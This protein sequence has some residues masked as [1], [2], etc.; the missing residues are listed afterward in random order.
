[1]TGFIR[2][3]L[4]C[5]LFF[6]SACVEPS[7]EQ[8]FQEGMEFA[9]GGNQQ[10]AV[11][12]FKKAIE[13]DPDYLEARLE[14]GLAYLKLRQ[15][16]LADNQFT[17]IQD[18]APSNRDIALRLAK[19]YQ[20]ID[21]PDKALAVLAQ[22]DRSSPGDVEVL[23][24]MAKC[25]LQKGNYAASEEKLHQALAVKPADLQTRLGMV[26]ILYATKRADLG[27]QLLQRI[28]NESAGQTE[29]YYLQFQ[30]ALQQGDGDAAIA[31][32][33][34]I[35]EIKADDMDAA[36]LLGLIYLSAGN[37]DAARA[38]A[39]DIKSKDPG[40]AVALRLESLV[41]YQQGDYQRA[42]AG[43]QKSTAMQPD[44]P[45]HYFTGMTFY[46]LR[47]YNQALGSFQK[48]I[49]LEPH[50]EQPQ[51]MLARSYLRLGRIDDCLHFA[52]KV[53][54]SNPRSALA[55]DIVG[56]AYLKQGDYDQAMA[57][58][59]M[60]VRLEPKLVIEHFRKGPIALPAGTYQKGAPDLHV[61]LAK[62]AEIL[63]PR[64]LLATYY[65]LVQN[66][67]QAIEIMQ[68]GLSDSPESAILYNSMA[69][70]YFAL[71]QPAEAITSLKKA[72][73]LK[74]DY[75]DPYFNMANYHISRGD[76]PA[77]VGEY[78]QALAVVPNSLIATIRLAGLYEL[79]GDSKQAASLYQR[80]SM[81][82]KA[83]GI[84]AYAGYL[85]RTGQYASCLEVLKNG[86]AANPDDINL[87]KALG[88]VLLAAGQADDA[89]RAFQRVEKISP[90]DG[91]KLL[92]ETHLL[93][94]DVAAAN[95]IAE[96]V[97]AEHP[98]TDY[99]YL[100]K[101][102][103]HQQRKDW[104]AAEAILKTGIESCAQ[105]EEL[106]TKL[107]DIYFAQGK[108]Q[109][110]MKIYDE[111]LMAQPRYVPAIFGKGIIYD[112]QGNKT[113]AQEFYLSALAV[114][115]EYAPALNNLAYLQADSFGNHREAMRLA[116][117]A[118]SIT[119][120]DPGI[121]DTVG[122]VFLKNDQ[123]EKAVMFLEKAARLKPRDATIQAHLAQAV[124]AAGKR[125]KAIVS[126]LPSVK[127]Q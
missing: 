90:A 42:L 107:A 13:R 127:A 54:D 89:I 116:I 51:L 27:R 12:L 58:L 125:S 92:V 68:E 95:H 8:M 30:L 55:H 43:L 23:V 10:G 50:E 53:L 115:S 80:A 39:V 83:E 1:M 7:K 65:L 41:D 33:Q 78:Q 105:D 15:P 40:Q 126:P 104:P 72:R 112:G 121:I 52:N 63:N 47:Q 19:T 98:L 102:L 117:K 111:I 18:Q 94:G 36:Y 123:P 57:H 99:G 85:S 20:D 81:A 2:I 28:I 56:S 74:P 124:R 93:R 77:A 22:L 60:A 114:N 87:N 97:I 100:L 59:N 14:L 45:G 17:L 110:A 76:Y 38:L 67:P 73:A 31:A 6:V 3:V 26:Q 69:T 120:E 16:D 21:K 32:L 24:A 11:I 101:S 91:S 48:A 5:C 75:L 113:K 106:L 71:K 66:Y 108:N 109:Q 9:K 70:A 118:Y 29:P 44:F 49:D 62:A 64:L 119:P 82:G 79:S 25:H 122:Y 86:T 4:V 103:I 46:Q 96:K 84:L 37:A 61:A 35:R 34:R 88:L